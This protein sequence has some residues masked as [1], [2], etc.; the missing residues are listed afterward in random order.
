[1]TAEEYRGGFRGGFVYGVRLTAFVLL[2][3]VLATV[4]FTLAF[5]GV[6]VALGGEVASSEVVG[7]LARSSTSVLIGS[8]V[9]YV[10]HFEG[11]NLGY[12]AWL[13]GAYTVGG[14]LAY[15]LVYR[16]AP[17]LV[18]AARRGST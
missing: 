12:L 16:A 17:R 15:V 18:D 9:D 13:V 11:L 8:W 10:I 14:G 6:L 1:M 4:T 5:V 7:S 2:A 3:E